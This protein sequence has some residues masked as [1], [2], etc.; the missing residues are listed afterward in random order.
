MRIVPSK[1]ESRSP[2]PKPDELENAELDEGRPQT[3]SDFSLTLG[4]PLYQLYIRAGLAREPLELLLRRATV[5]PLICWL[6]LL[7][8]SVAG[9]HALGGVTV[10]FLL[11]LEVH[12]RFLASL[13]LLIVAELIVHQR[14]NVI[15]RQFFD[16]N[17]VVQQDRGRFEEIQAS[18]MR[19]RNSA[20]LE[21]ALLVLCFTF[22]HWVWREHLTMRVTTWYGES[23]GAGPDLNAAGYWYAFV[24]LPI[25]RFILLRWYFRLFLWYQFLWRVRGLP[26][27]LKLFHPDRAGGLGFLGISI[28]AFSPV[29]VAHTTFLAGVIGDRIWHAGARLP[30]FKMQIVAS[31]L[32]LLLLVL[33]PLS[34]FLVHLSRARRT[35]GREYGILASHYV[36]DFRQ[37]WIKNASKNTEPLLG[38]SDIQ[39]LADLGNAFNVISDIHLLPY[40]KQAIVQL[41]SLLMVPL[42]PLT[43]TIVPLKQIVDWLIKLAF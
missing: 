28:L 11:D 37:K 36:D 30:D 4:G 31:V 24:S 29:L 7:V 12:I 43:L 14:I 8:L 35:A 20:L 9:G 26:L 2:I 40:G 18:T 17:I 38:T 23:S 13:P 15:V 21:I 39:S 3:E 22:G 5:I 32:L 19:M 34:F 1:P 10:P 27:H 16:R 33:T 41:V 25:F 6:P 42:L